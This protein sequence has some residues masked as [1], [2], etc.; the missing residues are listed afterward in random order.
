MLAF[1]KSNE[2]KAKIVQNVRN[3]HGMHDQRRY[4]IP[5][6]FPGII[7]PG[8]KSGRSW[9]PPPLSCLAR[10][11]FFLLN[12]D[13]KIQIL[14]R[15]FRV[16]WS[17]MKCPAWSTC[18]KREPLR[19]TDR[20]YSVWS[21]HSSSSGKCY[22]PPRNRQAKF[23]WLCHCIVWCVCRNAFVSFSSSGMEIWTPQGGSQC[24][25]KVSASKRIC[26]AASGPPVNKIF[27][28]HWGL[29]PFCYY[30]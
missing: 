5:P 26:V 19:V 17:S 8:T 23:V 14:P 25:T 28:L 1:G 21:S 7:W 16:L 20:Y 24:S 13:R 11:W 15:W 9:K 29:K 27:S 3:V 30:C 4:C 18:D 22:F 10:T 6:V 2:L 12:F